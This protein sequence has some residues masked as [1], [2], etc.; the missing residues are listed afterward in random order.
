LGGSHFIERI[1]FER[2]EKKTKE[3]KSNKRRQSSTINNQEIVH[4]DFVQFD[5]ETRFVQQHSEQ[6]EEVER[7]ARTSGERTTTT[8]T[9]TT[10][11]DVRLS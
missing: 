5:I 7:L 6:R 2:E 4:A 9:T 10:G 1:F 8:T 3:K 11:R